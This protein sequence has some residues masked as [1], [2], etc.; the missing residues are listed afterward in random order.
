MF[1]NTEDSDIGYKRKYIFQTYELLAYLSVKASQLGLKTCEVA[2]KRKYPKKG[3]TPTKI[4]PLKGNYELL[5]ILF[6]N[7]FGHYDV[8]TG[9]KNEV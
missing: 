5:K 6:K 3:K 9:D 8:D 2:V 4:S 1:P 7:A